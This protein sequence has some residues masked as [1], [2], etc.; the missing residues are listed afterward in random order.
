MFIVTALPLQRLLYLCQVVPAMAQRVVLNHE[1]RRHGRAKA[2]REW[3]CL[4]ELVVGKRADGG[5][6]FA[7]VFA[8]QLKRGGLGR[9]GL[10]VGVFGIDLGDGLPANV[11]HGVAA[12]HGLGHANFNRVHAGNVMHDHPHRAMVGGGNRRAPLRF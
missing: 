1:L 10:V 9:A 5:C 4:V 6:R 11:G 2:Q 7:A 3:R 12:G 8:Q